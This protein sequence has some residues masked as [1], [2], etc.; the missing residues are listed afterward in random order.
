MTIIRGR[1][2][3]PPTSDPADPEGFES[4]D[5]TWILGPADS[6]DP[7]EPGLTDHLLATPPSSVSD[8]ELTAALSAPPPSPRA[9]RLTKVLVTAL[10]LVVGFV[11]GMLVQK[12]WGADSGQLAG[13]TGAR[14]DFDTSNLP[15]G[16]PSGMGFPGAANGAGQQ[17]GTGTGADDGGAP[18]TGEVTLVDG[19]VIYL[20]LS[21]GTQLRVELGDDTTIE[22][23]KTTSADVNDIKEGDTVTVTGTTTD[24]GLTATSVEVSK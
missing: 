2:P 12:N 18:S 10:V 22:K 1:D 8:D 9:L 6:A 16:F 19:D 20:T 15:E 23:T 14:G 7:R 13:P 17:D 24:S 4:T 11:G 21:D 3:Q 5:S